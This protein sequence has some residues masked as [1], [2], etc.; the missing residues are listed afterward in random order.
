MLYRGQQLNYGGAVGC[1]LEVALMRLAVLIILLIP[2][3][4][5]P[6][7]SSSPADSASP[8]PTM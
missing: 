1:Y 5:G 3:A 7:N 8:I 6:W 2:S 4:S